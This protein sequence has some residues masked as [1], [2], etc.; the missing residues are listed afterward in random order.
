VTRGGTG[1]AAQESPAGRAQGTQGGRASIDVGRLRLRVTLALALLLLVGGVISAIGASLLQQALRTPT[2]DDIAQRI[3]TAYQR[4][5]YDLLLAQIDPTPIPPAVPGPFDAAARNALESQLRALD[6]VARDVTQCSY[7]ELAAGAR[8]PADQRHYLYSMQR[9]V[10]YTMA[11]S[12][13]SQP[14]GSWKLTRDSDFL[15]GP[16][17]PPA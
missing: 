15:G 3:C 4:Q 14:D 7:K 13:T 6:A 10:L 1:K 5:D 17:N 12:L 8:Q 2:A 9:G 11:M 16:A